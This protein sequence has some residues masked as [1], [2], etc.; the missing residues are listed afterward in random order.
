[1]TVGQLVF[2]LLFIFYASGV[3]K[4]VTYIYDGCRNTLLGE[5]WSE[6]PEVPDWI[7]T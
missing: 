7:R 2:I 6:N 5:K 1:M 3:Y 4:R